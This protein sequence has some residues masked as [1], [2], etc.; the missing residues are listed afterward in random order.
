MLTLDFSIRPNPQHFKM[1]SLRRTIVTSLP[2]LLLMLGCQSAPET[3]AAANIELRQLGGQY[4][5]F[6]R[7]RGKAPADEKEFKEFIA[8]NLTDLHREIL[9][10]SDPEKFFISS[11]DGKPFVV[12]YG[13]AISSTPTDPA[14][15]SLLNGDVVA[16]EAEGKGGY[17]HVISSMG[18]FTELS[19]DDLKQLVP[20]A[21]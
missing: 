11:R 16:Y 9:G 15:A 14:K 17:R 6:F 8:S 13:A 19:L 7:A 21:K 10:I 20:D 4:M 18:H 2:V 1:T 5:D 12:R 3:N